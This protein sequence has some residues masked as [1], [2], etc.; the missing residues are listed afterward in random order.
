M[1]IACAEDM[2]VGFSKRLCSAEPS[3]RI[4]NGVPCSR[5]RGQREPSA[6][7]RQ[8]SDAGRHKRRRRTTALVSSFML[9]V[10]KS[11]AISLPQFDILHLLQGSLIH[12]PQSSV[13][14]IF[15]VSMVGCTQPFV[16]ISGTNGTAFSTPQSPVYWIAANPAT[17]PTG[18]SV[19]PV[20][21][22]SVTRNPDSQ[23][24]DDAL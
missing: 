8:R 21:P 19:S 7:D 20:A 4:G 1:Q 11:G 5:H 12:C 16:P 22:R 13:V 24:M 10:L 9:S 18:S 2:K 17:P 14:C 15:M 6:P 3:I 23:Y